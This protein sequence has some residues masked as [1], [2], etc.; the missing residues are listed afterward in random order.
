MRGKKGVETGKVETA[1]GLKRVRLRTAAVQ[2][3]APRATSRRRARRAA[4]ERRWVPVFDTRQAAF[5]F[6]PSSHVCLS[7]SRLQLYTAVTA[8][9]PTHPPQ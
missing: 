1:A 2:P 9:A 5:G 6:D 3:W 4:A 7:P 8:R